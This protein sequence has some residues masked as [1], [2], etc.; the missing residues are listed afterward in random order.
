MIYTQNGL[1]NSN[2]T[3]IS[4]NNSDFDALADLANNNMQTINSTNEDAIKRFKQTKLTYI[5]PGTLKELHRSNSNYQAASLI[6]IDFD[7]ISNEDEFIQNVYKKLHKYSYILYPSISYGI[8]GVRYHLAVK[9]SR[10]FNR[11]EKP[12]INKYVNELLGMSSDAHQNTWSQLFSAP[13][14][15][16]LNQDRVVVNRGTAINIDRVM[17]DS[18]SDFDL[19]NLADSIKVS[20]KPKTSYSRRKKTLMDLS[21][22]PAFQALKKLVAVANNDA[23]KAFKEHDVPMLRQLWQ[24][25]KVLDNIPTNFQDL[26]Y[27]KKLSSLNLRGILGVSQFGSFNDVLGRN[28]DD[29]DASPSANIDKETGLYRSFRFN[30]TLNSQQLLMALG[31][32][33]NPLQLVEFL[34]EVTEMGFESEY[35]KRFQRFLKMWSQQYKDLL[36]ANSSNPLHEDFLKLMN[37]HNLQ[38]TMFA[39]LSHAN[40][41][42]PATSLTGNAEDFV[43]FASATQIAKEV[44]FLTGR[45]PAER[46]VKAHLNQLVK[47]GLIA[48][49]SDEELDPV[50]IQ[51]FR[52]RHIEGHHGKHSSV[53]RFSNNMELDVS[54]GIQNFKGSN[55]NS[56]NS[57][58]SYNLDATLKSKIVAQPNAITYAEIKAMKLRTIITCLIMR[59]GYISSNELATRIHN[60]PDSSK[61]KNW[62]KKEKEKIAR[63]DN[64]LIGISTSRA[65]KDFK[66]QLLHEY[67]VTLNYAPATLVYFVTDEDQLKDWVK[68]N[69]KLYQVTSDMINQIDHE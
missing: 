69:M 30:V 50:I 51:R 54:Q 10:Y 59:H 24:Q 21:A 5:L 62:L 52:S 55:H 63:V 68:A 16:P 20:N 34:E 41:Y 22:M 2:L 38:S 28:L 29:R 58:N 13:L 31:G 43:V 48:K 42:A 7:E 56:V 19:T 39:L 40:D 27:S 37:K 25:S 60:L 66:Q 8:K 12:V 44:N 32:F 35:Q 47:L 46:T 18:T 9:P 57:N 36:D 17:Q 11:L 33:H 14:E 15:T 26:T 61:S 53:F 45:A 6:L 67:G 64:L 4:S 3:L 65:T 49:V 1:N 23:Q